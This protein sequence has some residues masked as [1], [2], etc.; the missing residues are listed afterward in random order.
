RSP[1]VVRDSDIL[2]KFAQVRVNMSIPTDDDSVRKVFEPAAPSIVR[3][4]QA[5]KM[6][7]AARVKTGVCISPM[8]PLR[9]PEGFMRR[10]REVE[11]EK[12]AWSFFHSG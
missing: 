12:I 3:R 5:L 10:I 9:D 4:F 11:P 1:L 2:K 6:L 8:L 7:R